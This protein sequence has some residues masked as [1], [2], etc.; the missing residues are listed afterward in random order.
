VKRPLNE[1]TAPDGAGTGVALERLFELAVLLTDAMEAGL[2]ERGLTRPR[3]E[4]LWRLHRQGPMTQRELSQAMR[5]SPR[6]VS[7]LVD[8]LQADGLVT[9]QPHPTDRRATLVTLTQPG[10]ST[11]TAVNDD[12]QQGAAM[13]LDGIPADELVGFLATLERVLDRLRPSA[14][15]ALDPH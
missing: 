11:A 14:P 9:R 3:A 10:S 5:C 15:T 6:N 13:L 2:A 7:G 4:L 12:Y 8:A 1:E